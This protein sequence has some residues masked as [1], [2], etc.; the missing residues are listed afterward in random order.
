MKTLIGLPFD[1]WRLSK[2]DEFQIFGVNTEYPE[3]EGVFNVERRGGRE[4]LRIIASAGEGWDHVSVSLVNRCPT[5]A[6][7]SWVKSQFFHDDDA[8]M[9]LH[10][11]ATNHLNVHPYCLHL[12]RPWARVGVIPLP[13]SIMVG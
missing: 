5:W 11:A 12:W 10:V 9:Q 1:K 6:E 13:P 2:Q 8:V 4:V 3:T 7:M